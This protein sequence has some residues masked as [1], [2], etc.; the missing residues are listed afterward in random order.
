[1]NV[2]NNLVYR[3]IGGW[4]HV[5]FMSQYAGFLDNWVVFNGLQNYKS[6]DKA[7]I[8]HMVAIYNL[9]SMKN[10]IALQVTSQYLQVLL[11][12]EV[13]IIAEK[14]YDIS[15]KLLTRTERLYAAGSVAKSELLQV[16]AR[17]ASDDQ[18]IVA[19]QNNELLALLQLAQ[20]LQI[21]STDGFDVVIPELNLPDTYLMAVSVEEIYSQALGLQ[22][23]IKSAELNVE[24]ASS[25][26]SISKGAIYPSLSVQAQVNTNYANTVQQA[27]STALYYSPNL[28]YVNPTDPTSGLVA[29][30]VERTVPLSLE[31]K[32]FG[33]QYGDNLNQYVGLN[34]SIPIFNNLRV[35]SGVRNS[36]VQLLNAELNLSNERLQFKQ[37]I[38]RAHADAKASYK[39]YLAAEKATESNSESWEYA[40]KL[41]NEG[42][43]NQ[44]DYENARFQYLQSVSTMLQAKYDF[45][46]KIKVLEFYLNNTVTLN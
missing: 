19:A 36:K 15:V 1:M 12:K 23:S 39:S 22:P 41:K 21:D 31:N 5:V 32:N 20:M 2:I 26:L 4:L 46:F 29:V 10:D 18:S 25:S 7:G 24:S 14:Q 33:S 37:T 30:P 44:Y 8:D 27:S 38:Q 28:Q 35:R 45:I 43:M 17:L 13:L 3:G 16:Q 40:Q 9:E 34:L 42:A 6:I 11:N